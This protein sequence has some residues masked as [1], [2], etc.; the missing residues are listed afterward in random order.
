[1]PLSGGGPLNKYDACGVYGPQAVAGDDKQ[2]QPV[3]AAPSV[4]FWYGSE[5][6]DHVRAVLDAY[7]PMVKCN[8][9]NRRLEM[10]QSGARQPAIFV[11]RVKRLHVSAMVTSPHGRGPGAFATVDEVVLYAREPM[12]Q[13]E[14]MPV[15]E[16]KYFVSMWDDQ[17]GLPTHQ[18]SIDLPEYEALTATKAKS[19]PEFSS[20]LYCRPIFDQPCEYAYSS[21]RIEEPVGYQET[22]SDLFI[23][24]K[25]CCWQ[26]EC[27]PDG[28]CPHTVASDECCDTFPP[29]S[30]FLI[31]SVTTV[32]N[33]SD[34]QDQDE[35]VDNCE[36]VCVMLQQTIIGSF[37]IQ[38]DFAAMADALNA[39]ND[40]PNEGDS[41]VDESESEESCDDE[42]ECLSNVTGSSANSGCEDECEDS[43]EDED[44]DDAEFADEDDGVFVAN[45]GSVYNNP[46][47]EE[48]AATDGRLDKSRHPSR[49]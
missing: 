30:V 5:D 10:F 4:P 36:D 14:L 46:E 32:I 24:P 7:C 2:V 22:A 39:R 48:A 43:A 37:G 20:V 44:G 28:L 15:V 8:D 16:A 17:D 42:S 19:P 40:T 21:E 47:C 11:G 27:F 31:S 26:H 9:S 35:D 45:H 6:S 33:L 25:R 3:V 23:Y 41:E 49:N 18:E 13:G 38:D 1:M 34:T 12:Q 29:Q